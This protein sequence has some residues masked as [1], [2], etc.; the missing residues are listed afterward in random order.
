MEK[1]LEYYMS[2]PYT[3]EVTR[4]DDGSYTGSIREL[5][6]LMIGGDTWAEFGENVEIAKRLWFEAALEIGQNIPEPEPVH[7]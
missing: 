1:T 3:L 4:L 5:H 2:L 6:G 7:P